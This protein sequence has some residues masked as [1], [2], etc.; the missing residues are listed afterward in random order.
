MGALRRGQVDPAAKWRALP[1]SCQ[2][3]VK[4]HHEQAPLRTLRILNGPGAV[5]PGNLTPK[6]RTVGVRMTQEK[7]KRRPAF[8]W[9]YPILMLTAV[10]VY[11]GCPF[12]LEVVR[13]E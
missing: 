13:G 10:G 11:L 5:T 7:T 9:R 3:L 4:V 2:S 6:I 12:R 1:E 8:R